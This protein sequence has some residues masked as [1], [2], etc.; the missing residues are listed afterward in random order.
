MNNDGSPSVSTAS[1]LREM[2]DPYEASKGVSEPQPWFNRS[3][4]EFALR[5]AGHTP[6][7]ILM[8][9]WC[10]ENGKTSDDRVALWR[11]IARFDSYIDAE[12]ILDL[13]TPA[14]GKQ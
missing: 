6:A 14:G 3:R 4:Q 11:D 9:R 10:D 1:S 5:D 7:R 13:L 12:Q 8:T 2:A